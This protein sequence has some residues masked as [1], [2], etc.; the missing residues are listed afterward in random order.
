[1]S[2]KVR[3]DI[4]GSRG[5]CPA[6]APYGSQFFHFRIHFHQKVPMSEVHV[7]PNGVHAP[8]WEILDLPLQEFEV[9]G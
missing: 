1:M 4:A 5:A 9:V 3:Q 8:L 6:H 2:P 7:P